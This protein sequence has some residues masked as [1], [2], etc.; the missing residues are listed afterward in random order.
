MEKR[1]I[2]ERGVRDIRTTVATGL[3]ASLFIILIS[4]FFVTS[5]Q[6]LLFVC[7][8]FASGLGAAY[9]LENLVEPRR[10]R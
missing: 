3:A 9:V 7:F 8:G 1:S 4:G 6:D 5:G 10:R 2:V